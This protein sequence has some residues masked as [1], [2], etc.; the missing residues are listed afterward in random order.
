MSTKTFP[1]GSIP[2]G[3]SPRR[4][5]SSPFRGCGGR[6]APSLSCRPSG[7]PC[8]ARA[9]TGRNADAQS[10]R[11]WQRTSTTTPGGRTARSCGRPGLRP[12]SHLAHGAHA[13]DLRD[14]GPLLTTHRTG[15]RQF[16]RRESLIE[17]PHDRLPSLAGI[18][19]PSSCQLSTSS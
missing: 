18:N 17:A 2:R 13:P 12:Q 16:L 3:A 19:A 14:R 4:F 15:E 7:D 8:E 5:H 11:S 6:T 9:H 10:V 1:R